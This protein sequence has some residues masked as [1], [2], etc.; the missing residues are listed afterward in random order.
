MPRQVDHKQRRMH[1]LD[2][3]L[4]SF[5][6][7]G[8]D[9]T[10]MN[11]IAELSGVP[12]PTLYHYFSGKTEILQAVVKHSTDKDLR[13]LRDIAR[14]QE[15]EPHVRLLAI[16]EEL[17]QIGNTKAPLVKTIFSYLS[18]QL[19]E[20]NSHF[21]RILRRRT[22]R[23]QLLMIQ[24][25]REGILAGV[26]STKL[27]PMNMKNILWSNFLAMC[28]QIFSGD[29][30]PK[31]ARKQLKNIITAFTVDSIDISAIDFMEASNDTS[32]LS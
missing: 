30:D 32:R 23:L 24:L 12:R 3:A 26:F 22:I 31:R 21:L 15:L 27:T 1:I 5:A 16:C 10:S 8:Y 7:K 18:S 14:C 20:E 6:T 29:F 2:V 19:F 11:D 13:F 28:V 4:E 9:K 25:F 17:I